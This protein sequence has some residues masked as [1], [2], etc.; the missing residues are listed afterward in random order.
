MF[1]TSIYIIYI[2]TRNVYHVC[3]RRE[4]FLIGILHKDLVDVCHWRR[5][6]ASRNEYLL[7]KK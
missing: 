6:L 5:Y 2:Y 3:M 4:C 1:N 7:I